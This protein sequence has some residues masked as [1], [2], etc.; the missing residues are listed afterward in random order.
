MSDYMSD[1]TLISAVKDVIGDCFVDEDVEFLLITDLI[2]RLE[3]KN[4][5]QDRLFDALNKHMIN[6]DGS[7]LLPNYGKIANMIER[8]ANSALED[9]T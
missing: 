8:L 7:D 2:G 9:H 3:E 4:N 1:V 6:E 5:E